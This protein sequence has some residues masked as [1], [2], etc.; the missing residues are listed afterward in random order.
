MWGEAG[1]KTGSLPPLTDSRSLEACSVAGS[2]SKP[3][4][5]GGC[6]GSQKSRE[7]RSRWGSSR[8]E[9]GAGR[10][11]EERRETDGKTGEG[12]RRRLQA[13]GGG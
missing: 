10:G 12:L 6:G 9:A 7:T 3:T 11:R 4:I 1:R 5:Q 13:A 8:R 2:G